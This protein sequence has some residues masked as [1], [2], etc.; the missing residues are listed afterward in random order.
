MMSR[1][2][3]LKLNW[4]RRWLTRWLHRLINEDLRVMNERLWRMDEVK[5]D[6]I[7][8]ASH[9]LRTPLTQIQ[10]Y[11]D[12]I[13]EMVDRNASDPEQMQDMSSHLV[14][15]AE[16]MAEVLNAM[17]DVTQIDVENMDMSFETVRLDEV[18]KAATELY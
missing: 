18:I 17:M 3:P 5:S 16:R 12:L 2:S 15:A 11:A 7:S 6:F 9:E 4:W 10:G 14:T 1:L 13:H 8:I